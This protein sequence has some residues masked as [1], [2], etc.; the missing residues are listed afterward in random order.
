MSIRYGYVTSVMDKKVSTRAR[1]SHWRGI[2]RVT[3][4]TTAKPTVTTMWPRLVRSAAII[5][6]V[7][8]SFPSVRFFLSF[9]IFGAVCSASVSD[10]VSLR[11][12]TI[13][14]SEVVKRLFARF[15]PTSV[16]IARSCAAAIFAAYA[17]VTRA[18]WTF[19]DAIC[20]YTTSVGAVAGDF[21]V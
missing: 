16:S 10:F 2:L 1:G 5:F 3:Y 13:I 15:R 18:Q 8:S 4:N 12:F 6:F 7:F 19:L 20:I 17:F 21:V 14:I 11:F 9:R